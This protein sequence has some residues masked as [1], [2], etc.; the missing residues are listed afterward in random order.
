MSDVAGSTGAERQVE[1]RLTLEILDV[2]DAPTAPVPGRTVRDQEV[3]LGWRAP[4]ANGSPIDRYQV[5]GNGGAGRECGGTTCE[6][7]GLTNG[8]EYRFEVRAH[9]AVGWSDWSATSAVATPDAKPGRVGPIELVKEGD[10]FLKL[11]WT[12]PTTQT[13]PIRQYIVT[14]QDGGSTTTTRPE[15][16]AS[17]LDNNQAYS[18]TVTAVNDLDAGEPRT[19]AQYQ[20]VGTPEAP[21]APTLTENRT[22]SDETAVVVT[23]PAVDPNGP[24][25]VR[26]TVLRNGSPLPNCTEKTATEL[27]RPGHPVRRHPLQLRRPRHQQGWPGQDG[28][29]AGVELRRG[30]RAAS[31]GP[32]GRSPPPGRT[33]RPAP[34]SP[35]PTPTEP[36]RGCGSTSGVASS[37]SSTARAPAPR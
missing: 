7:T 14:W 1:G 12:P 6:L 4:E 10:T 9:N 11:R 20:S 30:R 22:S 34:T 36:S 15:V 32:T 3:A 29:R 35:C 25:P 28:E 19:S 5:R 18:F 31:R 33:T 37:A 8:R 23:W 13:S 26:Y 16:T 17:G 21:A 2:P 27:R 24:D